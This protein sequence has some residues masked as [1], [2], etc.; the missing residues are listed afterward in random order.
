MLEVIFD[1]KKKKIAESALD[2]DN[3]EVTT[4]IA[5]YIARKLFKRSKYES[6]KIS[7]KV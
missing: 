3:V 7:I 2:E 1:T 6:C 5:V 4:T